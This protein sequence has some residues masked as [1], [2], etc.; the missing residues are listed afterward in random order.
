MRAVT[1]VLRGRFRQYWKSWLALSGLVAPRTA[2]RARPSGAASAAAG[3]D[4]AH[5]VVGGD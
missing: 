4:P 3:S 1:M 5:L 2:R